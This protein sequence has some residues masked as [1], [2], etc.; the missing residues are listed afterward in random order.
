MPRRYHAACVEALV[1]G[2]P[3]FRSALFSSG[4][5]LAVVVVGRRTLSFASFRFFLAVLLRCW[6]H[7][8]H[9]CVSFLLMLLR[10]G[11]LRAVYIP[12]LSNVLSV[13]SC[14]TVNSMEFRHKNE[15]R[16]FSIIC[17]VATRAVQVSES[18]VAP[19]TLLCFILCHVYWWRHVLKAWTGPYGF[20]ICIL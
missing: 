8:V 15:K 14:M 3:S 9:V 4:D 2:V 1:F 17:L 16:I 18:C 20:A 12:F 11:V 19:V 5:R 13:L 7:N 6:M 10:Q